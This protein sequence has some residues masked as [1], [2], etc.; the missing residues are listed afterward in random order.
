[1]P[2]SADIS[3][4]YV[5]QELIEA[6]P[7]TQTLR[8]GIV[9][10]FDDL[11]IIVTMFAHNGDAY[12]LMVK[13]DNYKEYPPLFDFIDPESGVVGTK[14]AYPK[15]HDSFFHESG[16]CICAPF[17]RKAYKSYVDSGPHGDWAYAD[18]TTS[19]ASGLDWSNYS[20]LGDMLGLIHTRLNNSGYYKGR[21][22]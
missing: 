1:M 18:W 5:E 10:R 7:I 21:M 22:A 16:P 6:R 19:K 13:L 11:S 9:P 4:S 8:L 2:V 20:R 17:N 15:T 12:I 14:H 3:R